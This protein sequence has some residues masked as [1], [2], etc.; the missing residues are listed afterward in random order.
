MT[1]GCS[2][3]AE[4]QRKATAIVNLARVIAGGHIYHFVVAA[5]RAKESQFA[6]YKNEHL[7]LLLVPSLTSFALASTTHARCE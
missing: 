5:W 6:A 4:L 3:T 2:P 1:V 7:Y